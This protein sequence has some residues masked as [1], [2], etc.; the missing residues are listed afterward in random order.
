[1]RATPRTRVIVLAR[2]QMRWA[3]KV[4]FSLGH[5]FPEPAAVRGHDFCTIFSHSVFYERGDKLYADCEP[6][7][8]FL[9]FFPHLLLLPRPLLLPPIPFRLPALPHRDMQVDDFRCS[10]FPQPVCF[11]SFSSSS[12]TAPKLAGLD[13]TFPSYP[14]VIT[15]P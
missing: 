9:R 3:E 11:H 7:I 12:D 6:R 8:C 5:V 13:R 15:R 14:H 1:M 10:C 2:Q 4:R